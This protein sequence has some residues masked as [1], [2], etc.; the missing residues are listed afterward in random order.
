M[1]SLLVVL[2]AWDMFAYGVIGVCVI[3]GVGMKMGC[4]ELGRFYLI[5]R[6]NRD[7]LLHM[8][9]TRPN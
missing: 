2:C 3:L 7:A 8:T 6:F 1:C 5:A 4:M 9:D